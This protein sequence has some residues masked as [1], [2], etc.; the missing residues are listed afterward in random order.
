[1][2][3]RTMRRFAITLPV[4]L[5]T[6]CGLGS[7]LTNASA[8]NDQYKSCVINQIEDLQTSNRVEGMDA[9]IVT[10]LVITACKNREDTYVV[11]MTDLAMVLSGNMVTREKFL[12]D[13]EDELRSD[14]HDLAHDLVADRL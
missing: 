6:G 5:L 7:A 3:E 13:E 10:S 14:L 2:G 9:Q 4:L 12:E 11:A 1:M 8:E